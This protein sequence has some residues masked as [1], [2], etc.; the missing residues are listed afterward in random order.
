M[1]QETSKMKRA[2]DYHL[3]EEIRRIFR[4]ERNRDR[5]KCNIVAYGIPLQS[6]INGDQEFVIKHLTEHCD[7]TDVS[8]S[9]FRWILPNNKPLTTQQPIR[10]AGISHQGSI[11]SQPPPTLFSVQNLDVKKHILQRSYEL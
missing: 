5:K 10:Q 3:K 4:Q 8:I 9:N 2:I 6:R 1:Q 7:I 11:P